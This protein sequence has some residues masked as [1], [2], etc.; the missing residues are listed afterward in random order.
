MAGDPINPDNPDGPKYP[1]GTAAKDLSKKVSR[2]IRYQFE[3]GEL[4]G[5]DNVQTISFSRNVTIDVVAGTKVYTD[6]LNDSSLTG[7]YKAVDSPMIAGYTADIL[8]VAGN[9]SVLG[10]DQDN[11]IVVTYTASSKE[12]T[13]TYVDTTTGA[14]L[15]TVSLSGTPDTPSDYR[16][17]TTIAAYVKQG[18]ELVSDDYPTSGA[19]FS[20]GGVN[21]T[22]RLAHAT[23]TTPETKT[24]TQTV[25]YQASNGTPL[26]TD[27]ISTITF[28]RTKVVDHVTGT[29][30]YSGWVTSKDDNT[31]VSVPAIAISGYHPSVTGTQAVTVTP[32]SADDVQ[33][34]DYVADTVTI[35]TP[36]QPLKVKKSQKKQ[37][38]VVQVKQLKK[39]KQPVQMA[40]ATAAALELGKTIRPIKQA[41][42]NKQAVENKQVTT[43]EQA[44]TQKRAT[45]PQTNDNRQ[46]SVTAEILGLI[47]AALLAGLSAM[48]KRRHEGW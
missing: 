15:A 26:H 40:G 7:S 32:D 17:A 21:Y 27:T 34:I 33:T 16:T 20:E 22:V 42:K 9:T 24:I 37:K 28:T 31:F 48:L 30:V 41:A 46:A 13:V 6:W 1:N 29:V 38:K 14:V 18:Y 35:K 43:R 5:M 19:P 23:D 10:T 2:T 12:A 39:I 11:D 25:H 44:T 36:D 8:R 45:L 47:V 4:A 3:N